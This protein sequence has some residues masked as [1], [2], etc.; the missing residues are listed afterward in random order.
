M[1]K[2]LFALV[3]GIVMIAIASCGNKNK[4]SEAYNKA[5]KVLDSVTERVQITRDCD[6]IDALFVTRV[7]CLQDINSMPQSERDELTKLKNDFDKAMERK[8]AELKCYEEIEVIETETM[9]FDDPFE[10]E[11]EFED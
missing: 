6:E 10:Y 11:D 7:N 1:K 5:K 9:P 4:H 2:I 8:K 3:M